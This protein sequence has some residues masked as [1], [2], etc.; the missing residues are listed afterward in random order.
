MI[1]KSNP[2]KAGGIKLKLPVGL[3][4]LLKTRLSREREKLW[5]FFFFFNFQYYLKINFPRKLYRKPSSRLENMKIFFEFQNANQ[6]EFRI[7]KK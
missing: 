5:V 6:T 1:E 7:K 3:W 4:F 2:K